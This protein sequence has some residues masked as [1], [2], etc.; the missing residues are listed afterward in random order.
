MN[1]QATRHPIKNRARRYHIKVCQRCRCRCKKS[2]ENKRSRHSFKHRH[3]LRE[4]GKKTYVLSYA[5]VS[6]P[7]STS[8]PSISVSIHASPSLFSSPVHRRGTSSGE[9]GLRGFLD[10][11]GSRKLL[12]RDN[13]SKATVPTVAN[14]SS[15]LYT[16]SWS[17]G[18]RST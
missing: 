12:R 5:A 2:N 9:N 14:T 7:T 17:A 18:R 10:D 6:D 11:G 13:G 8:D 16:F 4:K 1:W 15:L 3:R